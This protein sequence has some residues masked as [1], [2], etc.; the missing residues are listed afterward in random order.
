MLGVE[1]WGSCFVVYPAAWRSSGGDTL[2]QRMLRAGT[3]RSEQP[4]EPADRG[5][6]RCISAA[7]QV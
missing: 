3:S 4:R 1:V 2:K 6:R 5:G 7:S